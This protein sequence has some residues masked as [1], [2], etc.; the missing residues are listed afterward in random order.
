MNI[1]R[2]C[3]YYEDG[4][5]IG[6][7]LCYD[8]TNVVSLNCVNKEIGIV[9]ERNFIY[10]VFTQSGE[11]KYFEYKILSTKNKIKTIKTQHMKIINFRR[12]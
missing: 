7:F 4:F 1:S 9:L 12:A 6:D 10:S 11:R 3:E 8:K 2:F 5:N